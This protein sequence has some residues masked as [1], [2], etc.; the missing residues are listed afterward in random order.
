M[1]LRFKKQHFGL[2]FEWE[3][4]V[5]DCFRFGFGIAGLVG[6]VD[7]GDLHFLSRDMFILGFL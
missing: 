3:S 4:A 7:F 6:S 2:G 1:S 5:E